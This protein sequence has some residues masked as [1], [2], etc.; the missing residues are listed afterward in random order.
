[1]KQKIALLMATVVLIFSVAGC[2]ENTS[3]K[4]TTEVLPTLNSYY[5]MELPPLTDSECAMIEHSIDVIR[6]FLNDEI[7]ADFTHTTI[8][9]YYETLSL[10]L[11]NQENINISL[12]LSSYSLALNELNAFSCGYSYASKE[13]LE[14]YVNEI[15]RSYN[16]YVEMS[17]KN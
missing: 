15:E 11:E 2:G 16:T 10:S 7:Y 4:D 17:Q 13:A 8:K 12:I 5:T 3:A 14:M 6:A 9:T 1:M